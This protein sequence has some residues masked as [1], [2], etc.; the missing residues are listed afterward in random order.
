[1]NIFN[2]LRVYAGKWAV[3]GSRKFTAEEIAEVKS[4]TV[5]DSQYGLS[6]CFFLSSGQ[7]FIPLSTESN[8]VAGDTVDVSKAQLLTLSKDGESDIT[9][10]EA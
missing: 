1:M 4:A 3:S 2:N 9:R 5:V 6:V 8:L 10:I 7:S